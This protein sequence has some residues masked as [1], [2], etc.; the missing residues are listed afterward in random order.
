MKQLFN[1]SGLIHTL[2]LLV[3]VAAVGVISF[4]LISSTVPLNGLFGLLNLKPSS[5]AATSNIID[6]AYPCGFT[7]P[8]F[9]DNFSQGPAPVKG[10][11]NDLD[12]RKWSFTRVSGHNSGDGQIFGWGQIAKTEHCRT[13]GLNVDAPFDSFFCGSEV[14]EPEHWMEAID[15]HDGYVYNGARIRQ[16]FDFTNRTGTVQWGVDAKNSSTHGWWLETWVTDTPTMGPNTQDPNSINTS[17][18]K[19]GIGFVF[20]VG[21]N[22]SSDIPEFYLHGRALTGVENAWVVRNYNFAEN[23]GTYFPPTVNEVGFN[24]GCVTTQDDSSN[25]FQLKLSTTRAEIWASDHGSNVLH[26]MFAAPINPP[27]P[28]SVGYVHFMHVHYNPGK[29]GGCCGASFFQTYH[30]H[31]MGFDGPIHPN[32]RAYEIPD[33]LTPTVIGPDQTG[34]TVAKN[35]AYRLK[36][37]GT[38]WDG[39]KTIPQF[40]FNNVDLSGA[41]T[42]SL[43]LSAHA[44]DRPGSQLLYQFNNG[45][46][47]TY[48]FPSQ[49]TYT[50][51][52]NF[53]PTIPVPLSDLQ[54]GTNTLKMKAITSG[55]YL[56][57]NSI[58]VANIDLEINPPDSQ[59]PAP[60]VGIIPCELHMLMMKVMPGMQMVSDPCMG[61]P[62]MTPMPTSTPPTSISPSATPACPKASLG[63]VDCD[64][65]IGIFDYNIVISNFGKTGTG[66]QGDIDK[67][68]KVGIFDYN[69]LVG[70]F[71]K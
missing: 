43:N 15:D 7:N 64:G 33:S 35:V 56:E 14:P 54:N 1:Q 4:L 25:M 52:L 59:T 2:P 66:I 19:N 22:S 29:A 28:F 67:D 37:D 8:A 41:T 45:P 50:P 23:L 61:M 24:Q 20:S 11:G 57:P 51:T 62:T 71:G 36:P 6:M 53:A 21:C 34:N 69:I 47:R 39:A 70:N 16:P 60:A 63:D 58:L 44:F 10:R 68:G 31:D 9:C 48:N 30:W 55:G 18:P 3:I 38:I 49:I 65:K 12:F 32:P 40:T 13:T 26:R 27:L 5:K 17:A 42:A 46:W